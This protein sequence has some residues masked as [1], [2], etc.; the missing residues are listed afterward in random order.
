MSKFLCI[1]ICNVLHLHFDYNKLHIVSVSHLFFYLDPTSLVLVRFK[2]LT[3]S[4]HRQD[5]RDCFPVQNP[6]DKRLLDIS[7]IHRSAHRQYVCVYRLKGVSDSSN[8]SVIYI[9]S[10][11]QQVPCSYGHSHG[12]KI[13]GSQYRGSKDC[14]D[15]FH[16]NPPTELVKRHQCW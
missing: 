6:N 16:N 2:W 1:L 7:L 15:I 13:C 14:H 12:G 4:D 3:G 11:K 5:G 10:S 8:N 9:L